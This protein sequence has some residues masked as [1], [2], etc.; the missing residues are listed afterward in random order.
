MPGG[1][2]FKTFFLLFLKETVFRLVGTNWN[3]NNRVKPFTVAVAAGWLATSSLGQGSI[4]SL[5]APGRT[6]RM[7]TPNQNQA[8]KGYEGQIR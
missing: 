8:E 4:L 1:G 5:I 2:S 3:G 6:Q 7:A